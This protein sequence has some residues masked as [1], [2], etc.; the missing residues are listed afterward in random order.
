MRILRV[1][2]N[3]VVLA[4]SVTH[5]GEV[6]VTGRGIGFQATHGEEVEAG[7]IARIFVPADGRD[8]D[9]LAEML[10]GLPAARIAQV[11]EALD[12]AGAPES[13]R[14]S[15]TLVTAIADH[16]EAVAARSRGGGAEVTYPLRAEVEA[17]YP[18]E[19]DLARR[20]VSELNRTELNRGEPLPESEATALALH[21]VNAGF[22][23]GDLTDTYRMTGVI[24]QMLEIASAELG[25]ELEAAS[26]SV[27]RFITHLRYL[28][29]RLSRDEQLD[30]AASPLTA[31]L[32]AAY[33]REAAC[34]RKAAAVA[35]LRFDCELTDDEVAYLTLHIARLGETER[36]NN[37]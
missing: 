15:I 34:A 23:T 21:L 10:A 6:I 11:A 28:F 22:S 9:H 12:A 30:H 32:L 26:I 29:V 36:N 8:P 20:L 1:L 27:A 37:D 17:L 5:G 25:V 18:G 2:N 3:N 31:Q 35:E 13:L 7:K 24:Q 33:P 14:S 4:R 19:Y 16:I